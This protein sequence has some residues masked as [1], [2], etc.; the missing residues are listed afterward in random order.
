ML[1]WLGHGSAIVSTVDCAASNSN[2]SV[3]AGVIV[4]ACTHTQFESSS[5]SQRALCTVSEKEV[6]RRKLALLSPHR[7]SMTQSHANLMHGLR[8][9]YLGGMYELLC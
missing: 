6:T 9:A 5:T 7:N 1:G 2:V 8:N 3:T 4:R